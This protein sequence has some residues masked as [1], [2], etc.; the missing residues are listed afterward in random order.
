MDNR[1]VVI[2]GLGAVAPNGIGTE[3]FWQ[4]LKEGKN[5]I[6][7]VSF[8]DPSA[9]TSQVAAEI[10]DFNPGDFLGP[11]VIRETCRSAHLAVA[12][13]SFALKDSRVEINEGNSRE[14]GI[15]LGT[16]AAGI[17]Y[18]EKE[19]KVFFEK[20]MKRIHP[21]TSIASFSG[22]LSS[23]VALQYGIKGQNIV[24]SNGC[25]ASNDAAGIALNFIRSGVKDMILTGG[26]DA[27]V[28]P[29][30]LAAFCRI[31]A[32]STKWNNEPKR[33]SRPFDRERDGFILSEGSWILVFE[34]LEHARRRKAN[35]YAEVV[36]YGSTCDA[37]HM[38]APLPT[39]EETANC[40]SMAIADARI[41]PEDIDYINAH[42]TSTPLN[43]KFETQAIKKVFGAH[44]RRLSINS[45]KSM[46]G[47]A[48]GAAGAGSMAAACLTIRDGFIPPT[49]NY[50][51]PDPDCDLEFTPNTGKKR[52]VTYALC[53]S[54]GFGSKNACVIL[55]KFA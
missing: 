1:R 37:Y 41:R 48:V 4:G 29:I 14:I 8:F 55:K 16:G 42:G 43:D 36:G 2:T 20:G 51:F 10:R 18:A 19:I 13:T 32:V 31:G 33:A 11:K 49:I 34:E 26:A 38:T 7:R 22:A 12:A 30:I 3:N 23:I 46:I 25:T 44:A 52:D 21:Y 35:I 17:P 54:I 45:Q 15:I 5:C 9:H 53:N 24:V 47:H 27:C 39:S 50:E 28:T 40:M 6:D